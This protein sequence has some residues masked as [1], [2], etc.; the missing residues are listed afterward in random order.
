VHLAGPVPAA[1]LLVLGFLKENS[2]FPAQ[3][4]VR[5]LFTPLIQFGILHHTRGLFRRFLSAL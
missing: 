1:G 3:R 4:S 5:V 2:A